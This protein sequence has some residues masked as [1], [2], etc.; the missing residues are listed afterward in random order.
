[1]LGKGMLQAP[2]A[3]TR[4]V[5]RWGRGSGRTGVDGYATWRVFTWI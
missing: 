1:M 2:Q 5:A 3:V 4:A